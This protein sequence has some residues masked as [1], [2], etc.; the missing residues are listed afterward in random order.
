MPSGGQ[1]VFT[2]RDLAAWQKSLS[3][4]GISFEIKRKELV[5]LL[6]RLEASER[7]CD[8]ATSVALALDDHV[9]D[10]QTL[11][12]IYRDEL[13]DPLYYWRKASGKIVS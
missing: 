3:G 4:K 12:A 13:Q 2:D 1:Q 7:V 8:A 9:N 5:G 6:K 10:E 11:P